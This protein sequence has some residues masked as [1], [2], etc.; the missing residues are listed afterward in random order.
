MEQDGHTLKIAGEFGSVNFSNI[1]SWEVDDGIVRVRL[2]KDDITKEYVKY[3]FGNWYYCKETFF[4]K[5]T[6]NVTTGGGGASS[7]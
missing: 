5:N 6:Y 2:K 1:E 3:T 7:D 4:M